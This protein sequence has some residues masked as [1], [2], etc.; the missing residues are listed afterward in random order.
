MGNNIGI[1]ISNILF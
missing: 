1:D